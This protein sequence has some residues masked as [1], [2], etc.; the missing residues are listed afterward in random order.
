LTF[1]PPTNSVPSSVSDEPTK[2]DPEKHP[3][4]APKSALD[5]ANDL[6][7][8]KEPE[9]EEDAD[10]EPEDLASPEAVARRV[11]AFGEEDEIERLA[12]EEEAKLAERRKAQ[13][14]GKK[15]GGGLEAAASKR[16]S[17][18]GA[19]APVKRSVATP[20]EA[21]PIV[22]RA[23]KLGDWAKKN[24]GTVTAVVGAGILA[25]AG[26]GL[27][28][29]LEKRHDAQAS[30]EL[31]KAVGDEKGRVGDPDKEDEEGQH[32][33]DPRP[34]FKTAE[35]RREAALREYRDVESKF[36]GTGSAIL[37]RLSEGSLLLD[38]HDVPGALAAFEDVKD[39]PL[40]KADAEVRGR[41]LESLG[42]A[43]ELRAEGQSGADAAA[44]LEE[45]SKV[46]RELENTDVMGFKELGMYHQ[47]RIFEKQGDKTKAIQMLKQLHERVSKPGENHPFVYLEHVADD[48]L[49]SLDP[50]AIPA[51]PPG[52]LGGPGQN[53]LT[54]AQL[55]KLIE[56]AQKGQGKPPPQ[57]PGAPPVPEP[58]DL[59]P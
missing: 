28:T 31:A 25:L 46:F 18:I 1:G 49:R 4:D 41:A 17:K 47:A 39:S 36:K 48:R 51:K 9:R 6:L 2:D 29:Y 38:K 35:D 43:Y 5:E 27:Y 19:N 37:A 20:V 21:D 33:R 42:F 22:D 11:A 44:S 58:E 30:S 57:K 50:S 15:K 34:V 10:D 54:E 7:Q 45:A 32:P 8:P 13:R 24:Q 55:K 40:A 14:K 23:V 53:Q 3:E 16:L 12:R 52:Q 56:Q 59:P 26:V